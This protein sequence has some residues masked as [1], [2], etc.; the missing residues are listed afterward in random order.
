MYPLVHTGR[1]RGCRHF[2]VDGQVTVYYCV[3]PGTLD[4]FVVA[5]RR[6]R[7]RPE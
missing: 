5:V 4:C 1:Y 7:R 2:T 3:F 6:A